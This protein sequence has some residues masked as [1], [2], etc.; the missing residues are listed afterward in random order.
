MKPNLRVK[1]FYGTSENTVNTQTRIAASVYAL[2][3]I[4]K[5]AK[6]SGQSLH[7]F[8]GAKRLCFREDTAFW[9]CP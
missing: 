5:T 3:A 9:P 7:N 8:T 4:I 2:V 1:T 6:Y